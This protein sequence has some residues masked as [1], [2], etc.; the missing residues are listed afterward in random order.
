M[1]Y[2][3][4]PFFENS[5]NQRH[6]VDNVTFAVY[7]KKI[8]R[9]INKDQGT[10]DI[11]KAL[12]FNDYKS[13]DIKHDSVVVVNG[14]GEYFIDRNGRSLG[15]YKYIGEHCL[16]GTRPV[17]KIEN[18]LNAWG[19]LPVEINPQKNI[20]F[21]IPEE[22]ESF[23]LSTKIGG[24]K[25]NGYSYEENT[26]QWLLGY[27]RDKNKSSR[28]PGILHSEFQLFPNSNWYFKG[29]TKTIHNT[30]I[31]TIYKTNKDEDRYGLR[32]L[33][34]P[35]ISPDNY[36][37]AIY[38]GKGIFQVTQINGLKSVLY[39]DRKKGEFLYWPETD[40]RIFLDYI[41]KDNYLLAKRDDGFY[42]ILEKEKGDLSIFWEEVIYQ[43][44]KI[45]YKFNNEVKMIELE[46]VLETYNQSKEL[47]KTVFQQEILEKEI[48]KDIEVAI[49]PIYEKQNPHLIDDMLLNIDWIAIISAPKKNSVRKSYGGN[50]YEV[51]IPRKSF[52]TPKGRKLEVGD[53][54][55]IINIRIQKLLIGTVKNLRISNNYYLL[56]EIINV[57]ITRDFLDF[58]NIIS[59]GHFWFDKE[60]KAVD[61]E[62][63][64]FLY[65]QGL[66]NKYSS[67]QNNLSDSKVTRE[68]IKPSNEN[69]MQIKKEIQIIEPESIKSLFKSMSDLKLPKDKIWSAL[70]ILF[71]DTLQQKNDKGLSLIQE[72]ANSKAELPNYDSLLIEIQNYL[73]EEEKDEFLHR[74]KMGIK[75]KNLNEKDSLITASVFI[76]KMYGTSLEW[77]M[78]KLEP[79]IPEI[80][81]KEYIKYIC[82]KEQEDNNNMDKPIDENNETVS[83]FSFNF[84]GFNFSIGNEIP[85][86]LLSYSDRI[87]YR[88]DPGVIFVK[89]NESEILK[90]V[91]PYRYKI[92]GAGGAIQEFMP[93]NVNQKI[94]DGKIPIIAIKRNKQE[95]FEF[96]DKVTYASHSHS[97]AGK[98]KIIDFTLIGER[99]SD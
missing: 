75:Y 84:E 32:R 50:D 89:I 22:N 74:Y 66:Q 26:K 48:K 2:K 33:N 98:K 73:S 45:R 57:N 17:K 91:L 67:K 58:D 63:K 29:I 9:Y 10:S 72:Y 51:S 79:K 34:M 59:R 43:D 92:E 61:I 54:V 60:L 65:A 83:P 35:Y 78:P 40:R 56:S 14:E 88:K 76:N 7:N 86:K 52:E 80:S 94:L 44:N 69:I 28:I 4:E 1:I 38:Y 13:L 6:F 82:S 21:F 27:N 77:I 71:Q 55:A 24:Y 30:N 23:F 64:I 3:I 20:Y 68:I 42:S 18:S 15:A 46:E 62:E 11:N 70:E 39:F 47:Y 53:T 49:D 8:Q 87:Y 12:I 93:N 5:N 36:T 96:F 90:D 95:K 99:V 37:E 16:E 97:N 85:I 31:I 81:V 25:V 19:Y 41:F